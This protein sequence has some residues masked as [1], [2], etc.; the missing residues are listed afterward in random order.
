MKKLLLV[1]VLL[2]VVAMASYAQVSA[3]VTAN[4][5]AVVTVTRLTDL[6]LGN[7]NQ[8]A[9][10]TVL[11]NVGAAA[12]FSVVGAANAPTT[13]TFAFPANLVDVSANTMPFTGQI[14]R[15]NVVAGAGASTAFGALAGGTTNSSVGGQ[16]WLY[17]GGGVTAAAL[18]PAGSYT[19]T[20]T[21]TVTQP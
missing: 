1:V 17:V 13:C 6:A 2:M 9:T 4:V 21:V 20:L 16:L 7:V 18:Q 5:N 11:S 19:G 10:A 8:G 14:P 15:Y 3:N 12:S